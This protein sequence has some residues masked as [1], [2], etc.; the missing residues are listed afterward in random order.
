M[1]S[2]HSDDRLVGAERQAGRLVNQADLTDL[3]YTDSL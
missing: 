2:G 3:T 1:I